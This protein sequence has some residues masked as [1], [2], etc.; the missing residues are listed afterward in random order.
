[1]ATVVSKEDA[2][3]HPT[4]L[5]DRAMRGEE[6]VIA[7]GGEAVVRLVPVHEEAKAPAKRVL[8]TMRGHF[9][10]PDSFFDPMTEEELR[11]WG[12]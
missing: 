2:Y 10:V 12:H 3:A 8:G 1:M 6:I 5:F 4:D 7:Q 11:E 9:T